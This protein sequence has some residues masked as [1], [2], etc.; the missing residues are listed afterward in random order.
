MLVALLLGGVLGGA[1]DRIKLSRARHLEPAA[2]SDIIA[3]SSTR[4]SPAT[5]T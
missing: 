4:A 1:A 5:R 3:W 2:D